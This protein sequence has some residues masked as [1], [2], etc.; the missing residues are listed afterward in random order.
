MLGVSGGHFVQPSACSDRNLFR[1]I[2]AVSVLAGS[3][4]SD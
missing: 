1:L 3:M 4:Y 2:T